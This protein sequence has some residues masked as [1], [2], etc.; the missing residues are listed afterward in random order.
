MKR[1]VVVGV[2][3]SLVLSAGI[4]YAAAT[5]WGEYR[6]DLIRCADAASICGS[7]STGTDPLDSGRIT[8][9][10]SSVALRLRGAAPET[11]YRVI[12]V[13]LK[14]TG[15]LAGGPFGVNNATLIGTAT[16]DK[17]G[18]AGVTFKKSASVDPR[19]GFF[20]IAHQDAVYEFVTGIDQN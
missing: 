11:L 18:N 2:V 8:L 9:D 14:N 7:A 17:H 16:T 6:V 15:T 3:V 4:A 1:S 20:Y 5:S 12:F 10:T 19:L 13:Q